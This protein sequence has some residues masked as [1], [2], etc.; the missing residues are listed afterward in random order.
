ME[1]GKYLFNSL[2]I[3]WRGKYRD[4]PKFPDGEFTPELYN[5]IKEALD[6][7]AFTHLYGYYDDDR[8][9]IQVEYE[10]GLSCIVITNDLTGISYTYINPRNKDDIEQVDIGGYTISK[11]YVC[12]DKIAILSIIATFLTT[13]Q[14][15]SQ[16]EWLEKKE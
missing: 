13:G 8:M 2:Q 16:Y 5:Y 1:Y 12:D 11:K 9:S 14:P 7:E 15:C 3:G 6:T 10:N 4:R